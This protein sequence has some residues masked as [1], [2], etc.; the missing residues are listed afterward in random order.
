MRIEPV[1]VRIPGRQ[2]SDQATAPGWSVFAG[3]TW[4]LVGFV[5]LR[6]ILFSKLSNRKQDVDWDDTLSQIYGLKIMYVS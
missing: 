5:M 1:T 4:D 3:R 2:A 6:L